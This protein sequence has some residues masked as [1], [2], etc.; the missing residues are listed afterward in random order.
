MKWKSLDSYT[1][2]EKPKP[3]D[4]YFFALHFSTTIKKFPNS[5]FKYLLR[6]IC[7]TVIWKIRILFENWIK[8][9]FK[10]IT[11]NA[12]NWQSFRCNFLIDFSKV[13]IFW[14]GHCNLTK[15]PNFFWN[16]LLASKKLLRFRLFR[17]HIWTLIIKK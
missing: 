5:I 7:I 8:S 17:I 2:L 14:E 11:K 6:A 9:L 15:C 16:Y 3:Y 4:A 1:V 12:R 10:K 13:H